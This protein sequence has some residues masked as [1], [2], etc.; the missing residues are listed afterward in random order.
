MTTNH[1]VVVDINSEEFA[2]FWNPEYGR[3]IAN[4]EDKKLL[5]KFN[6]NEITKGKFLGKYVLIIT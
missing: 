5:P 4:D 1:P 2:T 3:P 6:K